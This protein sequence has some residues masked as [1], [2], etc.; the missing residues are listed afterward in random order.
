MTCW[1]AETWK[2]ILTESTPP[3]ATMEGDI[4]RMG[5]VKRA[6]WQ[7]HEVSWHL[8]KE[9]EHAKSWFRLTA[10]NYMC[11]FMEKKNDV[12]IYGSCFLDTFN[13]RV[14]FC[15]LIKMLWYPSEA[16]RSWKKKRNWNDIKIET[17]LASEGIFNKSQL[18][19]PLILNQ[20][21]LKD[22]TVSNFWL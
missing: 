22:N 12:N 1:H 8:T 15:I 9:C 21:S 20:K 17:A 13:Q 16:P 3:A 10:G 14:L 4:V 5:N 6:V 18:L 11:S 19:I 2:F 7:Q